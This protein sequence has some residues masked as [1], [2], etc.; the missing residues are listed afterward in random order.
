MF[1]L[2]RLLFTITFFLGVVALFFSALMFA[3]KIW[4]IYCMPS[5]EKIPRGA[6]LI[7]SRND[8]EPF[9]NAPDRPI[10][11]P[12]EEKLRGPSMFGSGPI[13]RRPVTERMIV[14]LP[15]IKWLHE[16]AKDSTSTLYRIY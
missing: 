11:K 2:I 7:V 14:R 6:T 15:Y 3:A 4:G 10:P 12:V 8:D 16:Q 13:K 5:N 1:K 9:L